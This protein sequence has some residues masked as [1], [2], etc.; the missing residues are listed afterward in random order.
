MSETPVEPTQSGTTSDCGLFYDVVSGDTI[1]RSSCGIIALTFGST[2]R[3]VLQLLLVSRPPQTARVV[4]RTEIPFAQ[5]MTGAAISMG[6]AEAEKIIVV[7]AIAMQET[8]MVPM[9]GSA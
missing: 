6:I 2:T 1:D 9:V 5:E 7:L 4:P 3:S 8:V